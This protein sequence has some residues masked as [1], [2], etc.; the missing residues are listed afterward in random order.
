MYI[1]DGTGNV[2]QTDALSHVMH[3]H[4]ALKG[5]SEEAVKVQTPK[6]LHSHQERPI[7]ELDNECL[8]RAVSEK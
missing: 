8:G 1:L 4:W 7:L 2:T 6:A 5:R 3:A